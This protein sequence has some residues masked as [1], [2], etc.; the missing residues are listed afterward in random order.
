M[1]GLWEKWKTKWNVES[2]KRMTWIFISCCFFVFH[3]SA[4][5]NI[6]E[7][8]EEVLQCVLNN[9]TV[10]IQELFLSEEELKTIA[11]DINLNKFLEDSIK[12]DSVYNEMQNMLVDF[13]S[14]NY[15]RAQ[16]IGV[17]DGYTE[18]TTQP[19]DS[20]AFMACM[21]L[22]NPVYKYFYFSYKKI[23]HRFA[24]ISSFLTLTNKPIT[25]HMDND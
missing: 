2:D 9:D 10:K 21:H 6:E 14:F 22:E 18:I 23:D 25:L 20:F 1:R 7:L 17:D 3:L 11:L 12:M 19:I 24:I 13:T 5:N 4:Q 15:L 8:G 16:A